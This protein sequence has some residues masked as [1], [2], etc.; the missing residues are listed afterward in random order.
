MSPEPQRE[1]GTLNLNP[2]PGT[3]SPDPGALTQVGRYLLLERLG[4]G[5]LGEV[6][7]AR[8]TQFGRTVALK[9]APE[10]LFAEGASRAFVLH[11]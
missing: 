9:L 8:D 10:T 7:R 4:S 6:Y 2:E 11:D 3:P 1:P 5:G